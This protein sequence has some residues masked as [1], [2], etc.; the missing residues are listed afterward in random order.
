MHYCSS[1][2]LPHQGII[3]EQFYDI[4]LRP[5]KK[6]PKIS[7]DVFDI[8]IQRGWGSELRIAFKV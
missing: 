2:F 5:N 8:H 3:I 1:P 7:P 6:D 4:L